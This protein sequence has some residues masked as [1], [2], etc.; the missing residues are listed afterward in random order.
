MYQDASPITL[1]HPDAP[2]FFVL[3]GTNDS[4]I[5]VGE[6]REFVEA[7]R[8]VSNSPVIYA[9]IPHAQHAFDFFGS[10]RGHYTADAVAEFL[11]WARARAQADAENTTDDRFRLLEFLVMSAPDAPDTEIAALAA[12]LPDHAVITDPAV[13][14]GYRRDAALDPEA[15]RATAAV[16]RATSTE[17]VQAVLRWA[18]THM[19]CAW[20]PGAR[21]PGS[22][23]A[24]TGSTAASSSAPNGCATSASTPRAASRW[25][26]PV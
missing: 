11:N 10:P 18:S 20:C 25:C 24:P 26:N 6:G 3:H 15:G 9:E 12:E 16:V 17:D 13:I 2:P 22:P 7:L 1:V 23:A 19:V 4:L 21:D 8:E 5:P 14:E